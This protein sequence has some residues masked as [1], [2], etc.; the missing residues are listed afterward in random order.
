MTLNINNHKQ[1]HGYVMNVQW[2][3]MPTTTQA[4]NR[5]LSIN[6]LHLLMTAVQHG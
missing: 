6:K 3:T 2:I 5:S 1:C 4:D